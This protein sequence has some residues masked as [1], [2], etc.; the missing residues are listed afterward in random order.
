[1][2]LFLKSSIIIICLLLLG[3]AIFLSIR[4]GDLLIGY[5]SGLLDFKISYSNR[6][7]FVSCFILRQARLKDVLLEGLENPL[8]IRCKD[9]D[10]G[11]DYS[12]FFDK[13]AIGLHCSFNNPRFS[14]KPLSKDS[15]FINILSSMAFSL[16]GKTV[17]YEYDSI[18][19][20]I[21]LYGSTAEIFDFSANSSR[22]L[23]KARGLVSSD[24]PLDLKVAAYF[25]PDMV[26][27]FSEEAKMF[28]DEKSNGWYGFNIKFKTDD[29]NPVF[30]LE[31]SRFRLSVGTKE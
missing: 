11:F 9:A 23:M 27:N 25:S 30:Q 26:S 15:K 14:N 21:S 8:I 29:K 20:D 3:G 19:C 4:S 7:G 16:L 18:F 13:G 6:C 28:L 22:I 5:L 2:R 1:M 31:S 17:D 24:G 10:I 12:K